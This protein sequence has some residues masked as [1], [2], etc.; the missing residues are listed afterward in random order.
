MKQNAKRYVELDFGLPGRNA[1]IKAAMANGDNAAYDKLKQEWTRRVTD[2]LI[3]QGCTPKRPYNRI[4]ISFD[5][6][7]VGYERDPDNIQA[8]SKF[9]CDAMVWAGIIPDDK[10]AHVLGLD[11]HFPQSENG[12]RHVCVSWDVI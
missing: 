1:I 3:A 8:A 2:E 4:V 10:L 6:F 7:E 12:R 9:I 11:N 5:W